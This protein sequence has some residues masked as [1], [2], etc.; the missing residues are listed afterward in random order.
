[1]LTAVTS[2]FTI[3]ILRKSQ[4]GYMKAF[5]CSWARSRTG[6]MSGCDA[7]VMMYPEFDCATVLVSHRIFPRSLLGGIG[8]N[9]PERVTI[10][11]R[12]FE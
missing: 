6:V 2:F 4:I 3:P 11:G 10:A 5:R 9:F 7:I 12:L 8:Y 1:M